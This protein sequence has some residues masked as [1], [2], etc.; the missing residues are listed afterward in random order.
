MSKRDDYR[1]GLRV[2]KD[3]QPFLL[4]ESGLPGPRGNIELGQAVAEEGQPD[5]FK[6]YLS[7]NAES[8]PV[9]SPYEFLAFCGVLGL[10]RMISDGK[11]ELLN[12]LRRFASDPRWRIRE[13][14][15]MALQNLGDR[16]MLLL[17]QEMKKW[18]KGNMF[19]KRA[20]AA[21]LCE[22]RLLTDPKNAKQIL[23]ILNEITTS[24]L[25]TKDRKTESF[26]VLRK[27]LAYCWSVAVAAFPDSGKTLMEH[28]F[29]S[30]DK[31][32]QW[33]MR[34]NLKKKRL[35]L[36]NPVWVKEWKKKF[37]IR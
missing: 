31:D 23:H 29:N 37:A 1:N 14:A 32:I 4:R 16:N 17:I 15:A 35:E 34:E 36:S 25:E 8:A 3:W 9:N 20:A 28:W 7:Y 2:L 13:A 19:E 21:A 26:I 30:D 27:G 18:A 5:L 10:G 24:L 22:P 6:H 11:L 33:I 12:D